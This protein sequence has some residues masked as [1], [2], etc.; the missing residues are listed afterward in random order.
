MDKEE[1]DANTDT[2]SSDVSTETKDANVDSSATAETKDANA[3]E[4]KELTAREVAAQV[5]EKAKP[6]ESSTEKSPVQSL[7][8]TSEE[9]VTEKV[10][11]SAT[12][13]SA[14]AGEKKDGEKELP[15][16]NHP[17]WKEVQDKLKAT[18]PVVAKFREIE[19]YCES[20]RISEQQRNEA[21]QFVALMNTD[22]AKAITAL[23]STIEKLETATGERLP[24][25]LQADVDSGVIPVERAKEISLLRAEKQGMAYRGQQEQVTRQ[26]QQHTANVNALSAWEANQSKIDTA[27]GD[28]RELIEAK[29]IAL[30]QAKYPATEQEIIATAEKAKQAVDASLCKFAPPKPVKKVLNSHGSASSATNKP[31]TMRELAHS[32]ADRHS[33][34]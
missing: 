20:N 8:R 32:I 3:V 1:L 18:E 22:P 6:S 7:E 9:K 17:R 24:A 27:W 26:Q 30:C 13:T 12:D 14:K 25:D 5:L 2:N 29:F 10:E 15:F 4:P 19:T 31:K 23:R 16:H 28:K 21:L 33:S 11:P 34:Q